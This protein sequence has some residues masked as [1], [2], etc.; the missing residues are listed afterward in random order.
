M[1]PLES[2]GP[3]RR[4]RGRGVLTGRVHAHLEVGDAQVEDLNRIAV[5]PSVQQIHHEEGPGIPDGKRTIG[6]AA[7]D[8]QI[9]PPS[10]VT[11]A[12]KGRH[13][14]SALAVAARLD[15]GHGL[16]RA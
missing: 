15:L 1:T 16:V 7:S 3:Y 12:L 5:E 13:D 4:L 10:Q 9:R 14:R 11:R 8:R 6:W 2:H